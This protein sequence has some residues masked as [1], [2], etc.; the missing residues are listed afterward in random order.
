[1]YK[2]YTRNY[3]GPNGP[4]LKFLRV[5]KITFIIMLFSLM[6]VSAATFGQN[7]TLKKEKV[8]LENAF[9]EIRKQTGF[10][11]LLSEGVDRSV[12]VRADFENLDLAKVLDRLLAGL[13]VEFSIDQKTIVVKE[14]NKSYLDR[15]IERW[16]SIDVRGRVVDE[17][18]NALAGANIAVKGTKTITITNG[19]GTFSLKSV[20]ENAILVI[21]YQG[22]V[23]KEINAK[24]FLTGET[25]VRMKVD[26][27]SLQEVVVSKGYYN[28]T[29]RLN[30]GNVTRISGDDIR[31]QPVT[32]PMLALQGRVPGLAIATSSGLP[33]ANSKIQLRGQNSIANGNTPLYIVDGIP[34]S[35]STLT[36]NAIG[37][38][39][40]GFPTSTSQANSGNPIGGLSPFNNLNPTDIESIEV[41]KDADATAIY[42]SRGA[43][44]VILITTRKGKSGKTVLNL[45]LTSG[46]GEVA[47]MLPLLNTDQY[48]SMRKEAFANDGK[49]TSATDLDL[50]GVWNQNSYTDWQ[51]LMIGGIARYSNFQSSI[52]GGNNNTQFLLSGGYS[53][54]TSVYFY[55][56]N[57]K[58]VM[59]SFNLN[60]TSNDKKFNISFSGKY[61]RDNNLLPTVDLTQ[62]IVIAPNAPNNLVDG[63]GNLNFTNVPFNNPYTYLYTSAKA[64]SQ[65]LMTN[66]VLDYELIPNL[67]FKTSSGYTHMQ[68]EQSN[69]FLSK[70]VAPPSNMDPTNRRNRI[71]S[72]QSETWIIE[73]QLNFSK[74][75]GIGKFDFLLGSTFQQNKQNNIAWTLS[76]FSSDD[77]V[78]ILSQAATL[79]LEESSN[80]I[81]KYNAI[82]AR[83]GLNW[84]DKYL[85]NIT[86]R[87]DGSSRFG[88]GK[89]F[90]NFG[91][92][93]VGWIF[94]KENWILKNIP[95]LSFG[96]IRANYGITGNDQLTD[97]QFMD[98]YK[99]YTTSTYQNI[100]GIYPT[101]L[102][103]P[104]YRW[105]TVKKL[106]GGVN[107]GFFD[108]RIE[109][110]VAYYR[111][112]TGNQLVGYAIPATTGF[113]SIQANL[114]A[115]IQNSGME[116]E[117]NALNF[118]R[119]NWSWKSAI[120]ITVPQNKLVSYP[121]LSSSSYATKYVEGRSLF[122]KYRYHTVG[123]DPQT[124]Q[125]S[126]TDVNS[127]GLL[128]SLDNQFAK[129]VSPD[130]YGGF[131]NTLNY[132]GLQLD[133]MFHFVKQ[134]GY[135]YLNDFTFPGYFNSG[136]SNQPVYVLERWQNP[137]DN[138]LI[139]KFTQQFGATQTAWTS[140][141]V[142]GD[143]AI[144]DATFLRLKNVSLSYQMPDRLLKK[145]SLSSIRIFAQAQ[146]LFTITKFQG[147]DPETQGLNLPP[148]RMI[149]FGIHTSI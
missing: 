28:T 20:D 86:A 8:S 101:Q 140:S 52:S 120:N 38:G 5:M 77:V 129:E 103:N 34:Y 142:S 36:S 114:P 110:N 89:Q 106:E 39:A 14:K 6:Q 147:L 111:N 85:L 56:T 95:F 148:L 100:P 94:S 70:S 54:Q 19:D 4:V 125:Y 82:Y 44:G 83:A 62:F 102:T 31:K 136:N 81:Y 97:Y 78:P 75:I 42:G 11:V 108:D 144:V 138:A 12:I 134:T 63:S 18:G 57:D 46:I 15:I 45:D 43:N 25:T 27:L 51:K 145:V 109:L 126:L 87:R 92:F 58:K 88:P 49:L 107:L 146:N 24:D 71:A 127:D 74:K 139:Q 135:S 149:V 73:P 3:C 60:H 13:P 17:E 30:T 122:V 99:S 132:K 29:Q 16:N 90:G 61:V 64:L 21:T 128:S 131:L 69:V 123:V 98:L 9:R 84:D 50:N 130:F 115:V 93:G 72:N 10:D 76:N 119:K 91:A 118:K 40:V 59:T 22:Y 48:L 143:Y 112:R 124:G 105:E 37:G 65:N 53:K 121:G 104:T 137:G 1:M 80:I 141:R 55:D 23:G 116:F 79:R 66:A 2:F 67:H 68:L 32:D 35:S 113:T 117:F 47:R 7:V 133:V 26:N 96:K 41:L 33:G